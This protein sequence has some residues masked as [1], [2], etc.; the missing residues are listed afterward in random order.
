MSE[1]NE[2]IGVVETKVTAL[3]EDTSDMKK[4]LRD[5]A[6]S[7]KKLAVLEEK[8]NN[9][10]E[11]LKRAFSTIDKNTDRLDIIEAALPSIKLASGWIFKAVLFVMALL[12]TAAVFTIIGG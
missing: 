12:G 7:L 5:I 8:H 6:S 3:A 11:S 4:S 2:R 1:V 9:T 10:T